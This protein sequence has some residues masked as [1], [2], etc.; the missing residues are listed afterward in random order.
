M[1]RIL[2][3]ILFLF[4]ACAGSGTYP[5]W[6]IRSKDSLERFQHLFLQGN[7]RLAG[8]E[9]EKAGSEIAKTGNLKIAAQ[10]GL[11]RCAM[12]VASLDFAPCTD[13]VRFEKEVGAEEIA[14]FHFIE[15]N[16]DQADL[17]R[18]PDQYRPLLRAADTAKLNRAAQQIQE[19]VSR[20]IAAALLFKKGRIEPET[21]SVA[22]ETASDQGWRRPVLAWLMVMLRRAEASGDAEGV[23]HLKNRIKL[24]SGSDS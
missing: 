18:L 19:P 21:M 5:E 14:Y 16:W 13:F 6:K 23:E 2:I 7:D 1:K 3:L 10:A 22:L 11:V 17:R 4:N 8:S 9:F 15:G 12:R 20:L 24:V